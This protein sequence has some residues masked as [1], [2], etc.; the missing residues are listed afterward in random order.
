MRIIGGSA[1]GRIL[2]V[3]K[4]LS[5]RPTT[6]LVRQAVFNS[7]A[8]R[9]AGARVLELFAGTGALSLECLSRGAEN[10]MCIEIS[11][12]HAECL[13]QNARQT[14]FESSRLELRV[15]ETFVAI[16]QLA[17]AGRQFT[18]IF[19]DPPFGEKNIGRRSESFA[20]RLLD[21]EVLPQLLAPDGLLVLGHARRDN[22]SLPERWDEKKA[23]KHGDSVFRLLRLP[24][25]M[26]VE[27]SQAD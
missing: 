20:Q 27:M 6:D 15:Q 14:G 11:S 21:D 26:A 7:L 17:A 19:A 22:L 3:P 5:V 4:G 24:R 13:R 8:A 23:L 9:I 1:G 10:A 25:A 2:K 18:L 12:K 16:H